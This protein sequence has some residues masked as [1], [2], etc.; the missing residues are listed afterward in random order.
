LSWLFGRNKKTDPQ[1]VVSQ[2]E[3]LKKLGTEIPKRVD[4]AE[5]K[6]V[7]AEIN[8]SMLDPRLDG[9]YKAELGNS[10]LDEIAWP[11]LTPGSNSLGA[12]LGKH[13]ANLWTCYKWYYAG[14]SLWLTEFAEIKV[15]EPVIGPEGKQSTATRLRTVHPRTADYLVE[16]G[17]AKLV[18][19]ISRKLPYIYEEKQAK[20]Q[21]EV[22]G[23]IDMIVSTEVLPYVGMIYR[24]SWDE[25]FVVPES[26]LVIQS[27]IMM[28]PPIKPESGG[29]PTV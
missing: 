14:R 6:A 16:M 11:Y 25:K 15:T 13:W 1:T 24:F 10:G 22:E 21:D 28:P 23:E 29:R 5:R 4:V 19:K 2:T 8:N 20:S 27:G 17:E 18:R 26:P 3:I 12:Y 9:N 7:I